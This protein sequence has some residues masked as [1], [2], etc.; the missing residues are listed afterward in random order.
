MRITRALIPA[1]AVLAACSDPT[2]ASQA[3][4]GRIQEGPFEQDNRRLPANEAELKTS[5]SPVVRRASPAVVNVLTVQAA[6]RN[7]WF[8]LFGGGPGAQP[9]G[10]TQGAFRPTGSGVIVRGDG[11]IVTNNHVIEN[12]Q[13]VRVSL[14]DRREFDARVLVR[15]PRADLAVLRI[16]G[17]AERLPTLNIDVAEQPEVGDLVLA[18]GNPF[19]VGQ[20]VTSGIVSATNRTEA[21]DINQIGAL[22]QTDAA[23]N[24][25]NSGGALVDMDG[26]L[27]GINTAI[28]S[29]SG[30]SSGVGF[31][32]PAL[33]VRQVVDTA[34]GGATR[35][36]R[37][38]L[39]VGSQEITGELA[40]SLGLPDRNGA[41]V[42]TITPNS[43]AARA[44]IR[45][46]DVITAVNGRAIADPGGLNY[47]IATSRPGDTLA[48]QIRRGGRT[49]TIRARVEAPPELPRLQRTLGGAHPLTGATVA[50]ISADIVDRVGSNPLN[51]VEGVIVVSPGRTIA[52]RSGFRQGDIVRSVNGRT[53]RTVQE[54]E[55]ALSGGPWR[56][57]LLRGGRELTGEFAR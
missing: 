53:V 10:R 45:E 29:R 54:L 52:A 23:I 20:T 30:T 41:L 22:I 47:Q 4:S 28:L 17:G 2:G 44:G 6:P 31:A 5:F 14:A 48:I 50:N 35:V 56:I 3:Q 24:P 38:Y 33:V 26:D 21:G 34:A 32:V 18:I 43:P 1:L 19:G 49:E 36:V 16:E 40:E 46:G 51:V 27:I 25:G 39:G 8:E 15:D 37:P 7:P 11:I 42:G 12:A 57:T 9:Q 55:A 13:S